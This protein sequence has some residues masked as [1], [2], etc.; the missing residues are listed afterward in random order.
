[1]KKIKAYLEEVVKEMQKVSWPK[2]KELVSNTIIT[3]IASA[4]ISLF[5]YGVD[6]VISTALQMLVA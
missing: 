5:I 3:L 2:R 4:I 1:M 6:Q